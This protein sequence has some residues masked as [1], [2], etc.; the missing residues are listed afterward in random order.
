MA[1]AGDVRK[2]TQPARPYFN[3]IIGI[4][5]PIDKLKIETQGQS[6]GKS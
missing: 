1:T 4:F 3:Y 6:G 5:I 2:Y